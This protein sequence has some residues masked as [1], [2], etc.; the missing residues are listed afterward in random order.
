MMFHFYQIAINAEFTSVFC[1][2]RN[3]SI[4]TEP[5]LPGTHV[6]SNA[7]I[8]DKYV[9]YCPPL[10]G[11]VGDRGWTKHSFYPQRQLCD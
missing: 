9:S 2:A 5:R 3:A 1:L 8:F 4:A 11:V 10:A 7:I 6:V